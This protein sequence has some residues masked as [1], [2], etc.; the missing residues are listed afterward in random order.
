MRR[1]YHATGRHSCSV[2]QRPPAHQVPTGTRQR[3]R[4]R[5]S[6]GDAALECVAGTGGS[7]RYEYRNGDEWDDAESLPETDERHGIPGWDR[8]SL[9]R[10]PVMGSREP[11]QS[12]PALGATGVLWDRSRCPAC[13]LAFWVVSWE[14]LWRREPLGVCW[15]RERVR[16]DA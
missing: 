7:V 3:P 9:G 4:H 14:A 5:T 1:P 12:A 13:G 10:P 2:P 15:R 16:V 11:R 8:R 6:A